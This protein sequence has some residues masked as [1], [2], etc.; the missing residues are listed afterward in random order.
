MGLQM[1]GDLDLLDRR[2][3]ASFTK[4]K[5]PCWRPGSL[6]RLLLSAFFNLLIHGAELLILVGVEE[7]GT[8]LISSFREVENLRT[9]VL[10]I[11]SGE[12][13]SSYQHA[14]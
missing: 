13:C 9:T 7:S 6:L 3:A 4:S 11:W 5:R 10:R 2:S 14:V 1:G 8:E 12:A